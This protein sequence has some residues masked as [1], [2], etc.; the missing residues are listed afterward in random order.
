MA[1][2]GHAEAVVTCLLLGK[3]GPSSHAPRGLKMPE[4]T[5]GLINS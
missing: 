3:S 1:P 2:F 5:F 4:R